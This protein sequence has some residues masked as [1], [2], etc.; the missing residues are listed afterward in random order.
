M[1]AISTLGQLTVIR[2]PKPAFIAQLS[3]GVDDTDAPYAGSQKIQA[4]SI[5]AGLLNTSSVNNAA[6][7]PR[8]LFQTA[9]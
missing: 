1:T 7:E 5:R 4:R 9:K 6:E 3:I 2:D 8:F